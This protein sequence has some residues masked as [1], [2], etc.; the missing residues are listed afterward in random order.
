MGTYIFYGCRK[1]ESLSHFPN[2]A[3]SISDYMFSDMYN[4]PEF[5]MPSSNKITSIGKGAF[6]NTNISSINI[7]DGVTKIDYFAFADCRSLTTIT[8]PKSLEII[9]ENVF[10]SDN[11]SSITTLNINFDKISLVN[12][13]MAEHNSIFGG[14]TSLTTITFGEN[15][16]KWIDNTTSTQK[17]NNQYLTLIQF[18]SSL[19]NKSSIQIKCYSEELKNQ[20]VSAG[21][22][23]NSITV[24]EKTNNSPNK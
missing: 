12:S 20:L 8:L 14:V 21:F 10:L 23:E 15:V 19:T 16:V 18:F 4:L 13:Q 24:S 2:N 5:T 1:I 22:S 3:T 17:T 11:S 9:G 7:Q 6:Q